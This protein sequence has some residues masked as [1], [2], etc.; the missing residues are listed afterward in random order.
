MRKQGQSDA[1]MP[2]G[3]FHDP[4]LVNF[5]DHNYPDAATVKENDAIQF[6]R[7]MMSDYGYFQQSMP[8]YKTYYDRNFEFMRERT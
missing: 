3:Y 6:K 5:Y 7:W 4:N 1:I 2:P 8:H